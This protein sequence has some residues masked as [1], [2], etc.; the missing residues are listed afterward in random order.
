M[1]ILLIEDDHG[2]C[3]A[4]AG[5]LREESFQ[6]DVATD[7]EEGLYLAETA[8]YDALVVDVMLPGL[9]GYDLVRTLREKRVLSP[10]LFLTALGD[11][12]HRV[13]GLNAGGDDYLPKPFATEEFLARLRA[14][15]RRNREL[16]TDMTLRSGPLVLDPLARRASFADEPLKLSEKEFD[17]L[18]YLLSHRGQIL[19][20]EQIFNR[21][22]G[23]DSD[24]MDTTVDLYVHYLRKKLHP[25]GYDTAIRTVRNVGYMWSDP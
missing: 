5:I 22:W 11:V 1:R 18:E 9:S 19:L 16:G 3:E 20:R 4:L 12:D 15:L 8:V 23:I 14:L 13:Q 10:V 2:L 6:V 21:V 17:L 25:H 7:G 24:V